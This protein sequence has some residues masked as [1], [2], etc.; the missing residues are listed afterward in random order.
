[1]EVVHKHR[2]T[3]HLAPAYRDIRRVVG[4]LGRSGTWPH[5]KIGYTSN[6]EQRARHHARKGWQQMYVLY[7]TGSLQ[8]AR[9]MEENLIHYVQNESKTSGWI[10]NLVAGR[11]GRVAVGAERF[12]TYMIVAR[13]YARLV[14]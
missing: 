12:Y 14:H 5:V 4:A 1:M 13:K 2:R 3:G 9:A 6:P 10:W 11:N 8:Y 7:D